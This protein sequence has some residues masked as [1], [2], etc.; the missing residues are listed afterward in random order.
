LV[1]KPDVPW[2]SST[3]RQQNGAI[4]KVKQNFLDRKKPDKTEPWSMNPVRKDWGKEK[5][6]KYGTLLRAIGKNPA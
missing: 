3:P 5:N 4:M 2:T 6:P 1:E